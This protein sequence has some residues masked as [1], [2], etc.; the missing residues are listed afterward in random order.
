MNEKPQN[1]LL[2]PNLQQRFTHIFQ[3]FDKFYRTVPLN[4]A[5]ASVFKKREQNRQANLINNYRKWKTQ[6]T[7]RY[8]C[9]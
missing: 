3:F 9:K 2:P 8:T 7:K 4:K 1:N 5:Y 6:I